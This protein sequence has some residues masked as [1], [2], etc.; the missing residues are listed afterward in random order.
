MKRI[1]L[2]LLLLSCGTEE[3]SVRNR[4]SLSDVD[5]LNKAIFELQGLQAQIT[6]V[7]LSDYATCAATP[8]DGGSTNDALIRKICQIAQA[9]EVEARNVL[10]GELQ[11]YVN[12][13]DIEIDSIQ[14]RLSTVEMNTAQILTDLYGTGTSCATATAGSICVRVT[15]LET[16][17]STLQSDMTNAQ[18][19]ISVLQGQ[20]TAINATINAAVAGMM[21]EITIGNENLPAGPLY[22][23]VLRKQDRTRIN[24]YIEDI[25]TNQQMGNNPFNA[26]NGSPTIIVTMTAHG[27]AIGN[28]VRFFGVAAGRGFTS[29]QVNDSY[30]VIT[31]PTANTFTITLSSNATSG[32]TLGG[33]VGYFYKINGRGLGQAWVQADGEAYKT[34]TFSKPYKFLITGASTVFGAAPTGASLPTGWAG[35]TPGFGFICYSK[36]DRSATA[37]TI[38]AGGANIVCK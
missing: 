14:D 8:A 3:H 29:A 28:V 18:S 17:V 7:I 15:T 23:S 12:T 30:E 24:A 19:A 31:V 26:T 27:L 20:V 34:S 2:S 32:G 6:S 13:L 22:E 25:S 37:V 1:F 38:K 33:A 35:L 36:T 10:K 11:A 9:S 16:S 21:T 5:R 4:T